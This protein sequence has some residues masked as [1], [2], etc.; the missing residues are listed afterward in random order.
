ME[1]ELIRQQKKLTLF[2][3]TLGIMLFGLVL[4]AGFVLGCI[5][6]NLRPEKSD[7]ENRE[8]TKFPKITADG[9]LS[10]DYT[11]GISTWYADT[12]PFRENMVKTEWS[13]Q[14][15][16]GFRKDAIS[17]V[18]EGDEVPDIEDILASME[19]EN[20]KEAA[21]AKET[22]ETF[23]PGNSETPAEQTETEQ[24]GTEQTETAAPETE[25]VET[26]PESVDGEAMYNMNPQEAGAVNVKD[27][28]GYCVYGFNRKAADQYAIHIGTVANALQDEARVFELLIPNNSAILLDDQTKAE[29]KL[30][31]ESQVIKYFKA[32]TWQQSQAVKYVD[33]YDKLMEHRDEYLYFKTDHHW[34]QLGAYYGYV[35][36]CEEAGLTPHAITDYKLVDSGPFL[37]SYYKTNQY[38]QLAENPDNCYGYEP[39]ST[40]EFS[41]YDRDAKQMRN[42]KLVRNMSEFDISLKYQGFI[43]GDT[44]YS[45]AHNPNLSDG[46]CCI[47]VKESFGNCFAPFLIDHYQTLIVI[48]YRY[49]TDS[50]IDLARNYDHPDI[51]FCNNLEAISDL[52]VMEQLG[53]ICH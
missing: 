37:G 23:V 53:G 48:D 35:R 14:N 41:F 31:D 47:V 28:V 24:A 8:L 42:G 34:T 6:Y 49:N 16:Y 38:A 2:F 5:L 33:I 21:T 25:V 7:L 4:A 1:N 17:A 22:Q 46:S 13:I 11:S 12:F 40:N 18:G 10:G 30:L 9:F 45:E 50:L 15:A 26:V 44:A 3:R 51:I 32:M 27:L 39:I 29:W 19:A 52:Y 43:Y 20:T 36:F